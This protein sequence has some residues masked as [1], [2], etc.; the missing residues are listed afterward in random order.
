LKFVGGIALALALG[1]FLVSWLVVLD[2]LPAALQELIE[3]ANLG[4]KEYALAGLIGGALQ[5]FV[6][7]LAVMSPAQRNADRYKE[8]L[9]LLSQYADAA[10]RRAREVAPNA[11]DNAIAVVAEFTTR[12]SRDLAE[13]AKE[14]LL[15]HKALLEQTLGRLG[16]QQDGSPPSS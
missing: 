9:S 1:A 12:V 11:D 15:L 5:A 4:Q 3:G 14:W 7:A 10:L 2:L 16:S 13:E 6:A 8:M